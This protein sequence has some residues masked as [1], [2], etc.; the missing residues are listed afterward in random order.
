MVQVLLLPDPVACVLSKVEV[1]EVT[2][3]ITALAV[4]TAPQAT[5]PLCQ[6][7]ACRVQSRYIRALADL[8]CSG[9]RVKWL[10]Q[11][12]RFWCD[13]PACSCKIFAERV[14]TCAPVYARRTLRQT[15]ILR[16][17][18]FALGGKAGEALAQV[19]S[20][21]VSHDTL[22]RLTRRSGL[23]AVIAPRVLGVDDFAWKRGRRYGTILI[24]QEAHQVIDLLPDREAETFAKWLEEHPGV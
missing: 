12:R 8:P 11:V 13:N 23:P 4:A 2:N 18:A 15:E 6:Q 9:Q 21:P 20:M 7:A 14:P 10:L 3:T 16:E 19:L 5:C 22:L 1:D 24:D 17:V